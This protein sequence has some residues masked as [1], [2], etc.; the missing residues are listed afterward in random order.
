MRPTNSTKATKHDRY[1]QELCK[2]VRGS[3]DYLILDYEVG[4][5]KRKLGQVDL[6]GVR[7]DRIDLFE[8]KCSFRKHKAIKQLIHAK[9]LMKTKGDLFFYC[10]SSG[11]TEEVTAEME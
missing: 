1:V 3:Y 11:K 5:N 6:C 9:R 10:G 7:K 8:V 2:K 4:R